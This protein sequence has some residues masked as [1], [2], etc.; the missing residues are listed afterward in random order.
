M[1][2]ANIRTRFSAYAFK[3]ET[4]PG[5]DAIADSPAICE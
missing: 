2:G 3:E 1:A 5:T 4:T